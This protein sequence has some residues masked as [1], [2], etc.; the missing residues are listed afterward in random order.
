[1]RG[2]LELGHNLDLEVVA[3]GI[4]RP[5]QWQSL[6]QMGCDLAQGYLMARPQGPERIESLLEGVVLSSDGR[7]AEDSGALSPAAALR[8]GGAAA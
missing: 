2:I 4:E 7:L 8:L 5:E 6:Q 3:E 1:V